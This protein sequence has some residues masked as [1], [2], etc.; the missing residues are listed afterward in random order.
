[1]RK[2]W[3]AC[4]CAFVGLVVYMSLTTSPIVLDSVDGV[5]PGHFIAY[6]WLMLWFCEIYKSGRARGVCA[7]ALILMGVA[8][9]YAQGMTSYRT[10]AYSDMLDNAY[11]VLAGAAI[12]WTPIG[13]LFDRLNRA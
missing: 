9:E 13:D 2:A 8:L 1:L 11:G 10:F 12:A 3:L 6:A 4:G 7:I 5:K